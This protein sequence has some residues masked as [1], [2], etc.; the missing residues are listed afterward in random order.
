MQKITISKEEIATLNIETFK[1]Q[2][3][4]IDT[5]A[6]AK[7]ALTYLNKQKLIGFDTE[8]RPSFKKGVVRPMALM[9]L[10]TYNEC[11]LFRINKIGMPDSLI[12][13]LENKSITKIGLSLKD[14][15]GVLRRSINKT[16]PEGFIELQTLVKEFNIS[17]IS[18]QKIYAILFDKRISKG[19]Q[20]SN[21]EAP[22][23]SKAQCDYA[24]LD[25]WA[26]LTIYQHLTSGKFNPTTSK[27]LKEIENP[28]TN[29][30][31]EKI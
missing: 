2:I 10:S 4:I 19:Q 31:N 30:N 1:G 5:I 17:D 12:D 20:L 28:I 3:Y 26:C 6:N 15:F 14:D 29:I 25:A 8:T 22:Q 27:Y 21:W 13:F 9:Q 18:L 7:K 16:C 11:F 23:L 24:A